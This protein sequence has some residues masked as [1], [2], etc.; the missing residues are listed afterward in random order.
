[1]H[2]VGPWSAG[3]F[4]SLRKG[5]FRKNWKNWRD[6]HPLDPLAS[7]AANQAIQEVV[8]L[9]HLAGISHD[10]RSYGN[11]THVGSCGR[12]AHANSN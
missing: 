8:K 4:C 3:F 12:S 10:V 1:V 7:D 2:S 5:F 9:E 11:Q 6:C